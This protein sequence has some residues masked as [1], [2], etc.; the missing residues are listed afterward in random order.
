[1]PGDG[2][3]EDH[4]LGSRARAR[5]GRVP[6]RGEFQQGARILLCRPDLLPR[7]AAGPHGARQGRLG[8]RGGDQQRGRPLDHRCR[9]Q[10]ERRLVWLPDS[11]Q[12][13]AHWPCRLRPAAGHVFRTA[14]DSLPAGAAPRHRGG[15]GPALRPRRRPPDRLACSATSDSDLAARPVHARVLAGHLFPVRRLAG[16]SSLNDAAGAGSAGGPIG[17]PDALGLP[18]GW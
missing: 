14:G 15:C 3:R 8:V 16:E 13:H 6:R 10:P 9:I 11:G 5:R 7:P 12:W 2:G 1:M 4:H 17:H 18:A